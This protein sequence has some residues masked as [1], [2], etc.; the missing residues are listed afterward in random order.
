VIRSTRGVTRRLDIPKPGE[1]RRGID[2]YLTYLLRQA[3]A[4]VRI[5]IDRS[6]AEFRITLPQYSALTML[7]SYG[8]ISSADLARL[9]LLTPQTIAA[10]V[11]NLEQRGLVARSPDPVHGRVLRLKITKPGVVLVSRCRA[12]TDKLEE[13]LLGFLAASDR[14]AVRNWLVRVSTELGSAK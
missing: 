11:A 1:G 5:T 10:I 6:L 3:N 2:G 9:T 14:V 13:R 12:R 8:E 7:R 4:A